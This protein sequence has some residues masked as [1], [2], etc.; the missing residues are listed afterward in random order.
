MVLLMRR[1]VLLLP[2]AIAAAGAIPTTAA[3]EARD[4]GATN[5]SA[6]FVPGLGGTDYSQQNA[7]QY[8]FTDLVLV[9]STTATSTTPPRNHS[10]GGKIGFFLAVGCGVRTLGNT[11]TPIGSGAM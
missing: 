7:A 9:T 10:N 11:S 5:N 2:F 1:L 3:W 4:T 6:C 8:T